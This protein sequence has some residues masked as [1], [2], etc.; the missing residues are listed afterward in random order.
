MYS[1]RVIAWSLTPNFEIFRPSIL[2]LAIFFVLKIFF[3]KRYYSYMIIYMNS[4]NYVDY[5]N[6]GGEGG[7]NPP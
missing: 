5:N 2:N 6:I 3:S 7:I 1:F 4:H